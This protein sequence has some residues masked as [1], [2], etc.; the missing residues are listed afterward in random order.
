V[1]LLL[2]GLLA[3]APAYQLA[4]P[5]AEAATAA[6]PTPSP[7]CMIPPLWVVD[8]EILATLNSQAS[9]IGDKFPIRLAR[10]II[11]DGQTLVPVGA[12]GSGDVVH[13]AKSRFGGKPGEMILAA[14]YLEHQGVRI[15]L[16]SL[17]AGHGQGKD[18]GDT[19]MVVAMAVSGVLSMFITGGEV[20]VPAGTIMNAKIS[21]ATLI[22]QP[23]TP[24]IINGGTITP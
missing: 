14:R 5:V 1:K 16:R 2:I 23:E 15:P 21:T 7:C 8:I 6:V 10:A 12:T 3:I 22:P 9:K 19:A 4:V 24:Q 20:N 11:V 13:A 17:Q 18:N